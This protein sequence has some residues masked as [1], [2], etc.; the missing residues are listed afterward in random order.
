M[1]IKK[2]AHFTRGI[3]LLHNENLIHECLK[4][5]CGSRV[6]FTQQLPLGIACI[7][8]FLPGIT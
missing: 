4:I 2:K 1:I 3:F 7:S 5:K 6:E 8:L